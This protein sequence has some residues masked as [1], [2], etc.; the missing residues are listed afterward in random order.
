MKISS[1][2]NFKP[3]P[4]LVLVKIDS[5]FTDSIKLTD[6]FE[7]KIDTSFEPEKHAT[8]FGTVCSFPDRLTYGPEQRHMPWET[9]M[10]IMHGDV[11]Y[12]TWDAVVVA[13]G[14]AKPSVVQVDGDNSIYIIMKYQQLTL[15]VRGESIIMLNGYTLI[16]ELKIVDLPDDLKSSDMVS[17]LLM[18]NTVSKKVS[19]RYGRVVSVGSC[20]TAYD[21]DKHYDDPLVKV[22]DLVAFESF[23]NIPI[24]YNMHANLIGDKILYKIQRRHL[25]AVIS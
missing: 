15:A 25:I 10:E 11:V 6:E 13:F 18:P 24:Q 12:F 23:A 16:E 8:T 14:T 19:A 2:N 21:G 9:S 4:N 17:R 5:K 1:L 22:G 20:N 3:L 7:L